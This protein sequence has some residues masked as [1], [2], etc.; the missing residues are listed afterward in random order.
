MKNNKK[1]IGTRINTALADRKISQKEL[2]DYLKVKPN[3]ISYFCSGERTPNTEQLIMISIFLDVPTDFLLGRTK[4]Y[5]K[6]E[7][8][9]I[10][11]NV[12]GLSDESII[13]LISLNNESDYWS[14]YIIDNILADPHFYV[15][16]HALD[17]LLRTK[18]HVLDN[19]SFKF[20]ITKSMLLETV[21]N[22]HFSI[23]ID[24]IK[25]AYKELGG[26]DHG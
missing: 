6:D 13:Q 11:C 8:E 7:K 25:D 10:A 21:I 2:A 22:K 16:V 14:R 1:L 5:C 24:H 19:S 9:Q 26:T 18:D 12:T 15:I 20:P 3:V 23:I 17:E 4:S